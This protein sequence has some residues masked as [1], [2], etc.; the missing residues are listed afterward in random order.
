MKLD[1]DSAFDIL[2]HDELVVTKECIIL[3]IVL[4]WLEN[5]RVDIVDFA[6]IM[7]A[8]RFNFITRSDLT[9]AVEK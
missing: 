4:R 8:V 2:D 6:K 9:E 1:V 7:F 3:N 5:K